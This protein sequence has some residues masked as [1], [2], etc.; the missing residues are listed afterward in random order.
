MGTL[1]I[2]TCYF[3]FHASHDTSYSTVGRVRDQDIWN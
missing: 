3:N 2:P 1:T